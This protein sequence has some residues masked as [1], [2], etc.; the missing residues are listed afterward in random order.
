VRPAR[1]VALASAL[2]ILAAGC[3]G[4][5]S[6]IE[7]RLYVANAVDRSVT[8]VDGR[9]WRQIATIPLPGSPHAINVEPGFRRIWTANIRGDSATVIDVRT[10]AVVA[11]IKV[12]SG[13]TQVAFSP[14]AQQ[15]A[16][17][18]CTDG[19]MS[20]I[21]RTTLKETDRQAIGFGPHALVP[22]PDE[23]LWAANRGGNDLSEIDPR[24]D[25][26]V[27][28]HPAG[29]VAYGVAFSPDGK[30][31]FVTS[32][33]WHSI[34]VIAMSD[35]QILGAIKVGSDPANLAASPDGR[36][37]YV[38]N[39]GDGTVSVINALTFQV[40]RVIP[41]GRE[42][43]GLRLSRDGRLLFVANRGSGSVSIVDAGAR[44]VL[45]TVPAGGGATDVE[46]VP[47]G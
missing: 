39:R 43:D 11:T 15:K 40:V 16:F 8:V 23:R 32:S 9:S 24:T 31:A 20:V 45:R 19:F 37:V 36:Q 44:R 25:K 7:A 14:A 2:A 6:T 34:V 12:C 10:N 30:Y 26:L 33:R 21:D 13:P 28:R 27:A 3:G 46:V 47:F 29:P 18:A 17:V 42:P 38:S 1:L 5:P 35:K 4:S 41:V 22:G